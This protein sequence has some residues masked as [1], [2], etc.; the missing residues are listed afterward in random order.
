MMDSPLE[1]LRYALGLGVPITLGIAFTHAAWRESARVKRENERRAEREKSDRGPADLRP[2]PARLRVRVAGEAALTNLGTS[3][4]SAEN[5]SGAPE[6]ESI[7]TVLVDDA[8]RRLRLPPGQ[9]LKVHSFGGARRNLTESVTRE[10]GGVSQRF[11]FEVAPTQSFVLGCVLP[12]IASTHP[13][14]NTGEA[15]DLKPDGEQFEINPSPK[16][17]ETSSVGCIVYPCLVGAAIAALVPTS[18]FFQVVGWIVWTI[19]VLFGLLG[20]SMA[21]ETLSEDATSAGQSA[22]QVKT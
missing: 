15:V 19:C 9:K 21:N 14:R 10:D 5:L 8:G 22:A 1:L 20:R 17:A 3:V 2:G 12:E 18:T 4:E 16:N 11:S 13:F 7:E 6:L